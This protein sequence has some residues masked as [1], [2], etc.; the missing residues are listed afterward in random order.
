MP[1]IKKPID[2][3]KV[4]ADIKHKVKLNAIKHRKKK[5][6]LL[7]RPHYKPKAPCPKKDFECWR[8]FRARQN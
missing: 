6:K 2:P 8:R 5:N 1:V 4:D 7:N 3:K